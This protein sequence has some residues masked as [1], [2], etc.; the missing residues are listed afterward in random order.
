[1]KPDKFVNIRD[2]PLIDVLVETLESDAC[3]SKCL[4]IDIERKKVAKVL[5][6]RVLQ[7]QLG[8]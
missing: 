8:Q 5:A 2:I 4:D 7:W 3:S 1:M 6:A